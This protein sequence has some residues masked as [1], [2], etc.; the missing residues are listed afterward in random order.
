MGDIRDA[1]THYLEREGSPLPR[2]QVCDELERFGLV[3][4]EI[5]AATAWEWSEMLTELIEEG[6]A[7]EFPDG[8]GVVRER[9][10]EIE[11]QERGLLF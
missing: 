6:L 3:S 10:E 9:L 5:P 2:D 11:Q 7:K 4:D 1:L 8:V